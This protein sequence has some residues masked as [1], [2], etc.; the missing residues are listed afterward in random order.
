[1]ELNSEHQFKGIQTIKHNNSK[2]ETHNL[3]Y[4]SNKEQKKI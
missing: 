1:M 4:I 2:S 3:K